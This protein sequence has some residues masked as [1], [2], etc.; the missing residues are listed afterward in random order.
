MSYCILVCLFPFKI[1]IPSRPR[2]RQ[3]ALLMGECS[4]VWEIAVGDACSSSKKFASKFY[5][6]FVFVE[7]CLW[8]VNKRGKKHMREG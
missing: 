8:K 1:T 4:P 3:E 7:V 6:Y 2:Q 5:E